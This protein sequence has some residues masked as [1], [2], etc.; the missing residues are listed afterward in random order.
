MKNI[1]LTIEKSTLRYRL[2]LVWHPNH[3]EPK[4]LSEYRLRTL[5]S[6]LYTAGILAAGIG[7]PVATFCMGA[8]RLSSG[9]FVAGFGYIVEGLGIFC[10]FHKYPVMNLTFPKT[11][12]R[13]EKRTKEI[14]G[15]KT[16][17]KFE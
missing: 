8:D 17:V 11:A 4:T 2:Q 7:V 3:P 14:L 9:S 6:L 15:S 16:P 10:L 5:Y 1:P 13:L 12:D